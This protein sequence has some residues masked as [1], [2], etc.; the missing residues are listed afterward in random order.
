[1]SN[2]AP[3]LTT[4]ASA[5]ALTAVVDAATG[6]LKPLLVSLFPEAGRLLGGLGKTATYDMVRRHGVP[7]IKNG[8]RSTVALA[9]IERI[10]NEL[11]AAG[12]P[13]APA[14]APPATRRRRGDEPGVDPG[15]SPKK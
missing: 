14:V 8:G 1:M 7:I 13:L 15:H 2:T 10:A 3:T 6:Q 12:K 5:P 11:M 9:D 4:V